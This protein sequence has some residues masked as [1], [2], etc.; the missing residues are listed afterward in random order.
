MLTENKRARLQL[1][2]EMN[3]H[4]CTHIFPQQNCPLELGA[5]DEPNAC[6]VWGLCKMVARANYSKSTRHPGSEQNCYK[7]SEPA[8]YTLS[9]NVQNIYEKDVRM[10]LDPRR[11][12]T[13]VASPAVG[14]T[15]PVLC[16]WYVA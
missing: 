8:A 4:P 5:R 2:L 14:N 16:Y 10:N 6:E 11:T 7:S 1:V 9:K 13:S 3:F 12:T 15:V